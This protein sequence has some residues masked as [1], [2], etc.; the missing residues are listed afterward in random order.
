MSDLNIPAI[1]DTVCSN[2]GAV[3]KY[4][5]GLLGTS[6]VASIVANFRSK[7]PPIVIKVLDLLALNFV[8]TVEQAATSPGGAK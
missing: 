7:L 1:A 5:L 2:D 3:L 6:T 8:K 4:A